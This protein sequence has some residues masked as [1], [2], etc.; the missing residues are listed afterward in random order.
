MELFH[1]KYVQN[2]LQLRW[3]VQVEVQQQLC[4]ATL[5]SA[6]ITVEPH[7]EC[8]AMTN[9]SGVEAERLMIQG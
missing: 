6:E 1:G 7:V 8:M 9:I 2:L 5:L 4:Q 3:E